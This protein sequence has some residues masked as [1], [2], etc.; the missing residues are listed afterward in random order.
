MNNVLI[1][2]PDGD[3]FNSDAYEYDAESSERIFGL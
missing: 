1:H 3:E 2:G